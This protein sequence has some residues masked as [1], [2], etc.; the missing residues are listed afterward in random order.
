MRTTLKIYIVIFTSIILTSCAW[1]KGPPL[2]SNANGSLDGSSLDETSGPGFIS[3]LESA[4]NYG[5]SDTGY[6]DNGGN[7]VVSNFDNVD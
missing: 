5:A 6:A 1:Y 4:D 3:T 7:Y 2:Q